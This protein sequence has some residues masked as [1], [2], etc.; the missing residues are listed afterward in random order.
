MRAL[1]PGGR[2]SE[3]AK[4]IHRRFVAGPIPRVLPIASVLEVR[5]RRSGRVVRVPLVVVRYRG[6]WYLVSMFGEQ[7]NW[8]RN[9]RASRGLAVL[10]HGRTRP[11]RLVEVPVEDRA[12]IIKRY[13]FF[14][15]GARPHVS[16]AWNDPLS[17]YEAVA[18]TYP[19][20]RVERG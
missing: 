3:E 12:P 5:G 19:V 9:V 10:T 6:S 13:V 15:L 11:V 2:P 20:F 17:A 14:A 8:V 18:S 16:A 4:A 1:Y 7:A